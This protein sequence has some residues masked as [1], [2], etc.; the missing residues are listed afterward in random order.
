MKKVFVATTP[1][2]KQLQR[3]LLQCNRPE[4]AALVRKALR[5]SGREDLIGWEK[6]CLIT[7]YERRNAEIAE[8]NAAAIEALSGTDTEIDDLYTLSLSLPASARSDATH[9][10]NAE[11][12]RYMGS[13][14]TCALAKALDI[15]PSTLPAVD[16]KAQSIAADILGY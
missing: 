1:E 16:A 5:A 10:N 14:V 12:C 7:P 6:D 9:F 15:D 2:E 13:F 3:A 4:N 8:R 11:G